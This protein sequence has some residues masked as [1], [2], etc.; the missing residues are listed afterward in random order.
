MNIMSIKKPILLLAAIVLFSV[1]SCTKIPHSDET[2]LNTNGGGDTGET[3]AIPAV[4]P[5]QLV[6]DDLPDIDLEGYIFRVYAH[7][8]AGENAAHPNFVEDFCPEN[9]TG[10]I[11]SD[12]V[13]SRNRTVEARFNCTL[14]TIDS[15]GNWQSHHTRIVNCVNA[16]EDAFDIALV[17]SVQGPNLSLTPGILMNLYNIEYLNFDKPW[18]YKNTN[19]EFTVMG[20]MYLGS[21]AIYYT[22]IEETMGMVFNKKFLTDFNLESPYKDV[23]AGTWTFD[24]LAALTKDIYVDGD[25][26]GVRGPFDTYGYVSTSANIAFLTALD[27]PMLEKSGEGVSIIINN[28]RAFDI[29][30]K[31]YDFSYNTKG[32]FTPPLDNA[33]DVYDYVRKAFGG[34]TAFIVPSTLKDIVRDYRAADIEYGIIPYPKYDENQKDYKSFATDE[35][36]CIPAN[37]PNPSRTGLIIEALSAEGYKQIYPAYFEIALKKKYSFDDESAMSLDII[38]NSRVVP[39]TFTYDNWEGFGH[40]LNDLFGANPTKDFASYYEKRIAS[41][42]KRVDKINDTFEKMKNQ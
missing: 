10:D 37:A 14:T 18:W 27:M 25:G 17:H 1:V 39:F 23:I 9:Q 31:L 33:V 41:A 30:D 3:P 4:D 35:F 19:D 26:D 8:Y 2:S 36:F 21:N 40:M 32:A 28:P 15:G 6:S 5:R 16:G 42:Q 12:A 11:I 20:Q 29:I 13:Y 34:G 22:G 24:K 38:A 7:P